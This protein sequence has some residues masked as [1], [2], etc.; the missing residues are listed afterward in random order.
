MTAPSCPQCIVTLY[1]KF[2]F[3]LDAEKTKLSKE[4]L[5]LCNPGMFL[6]YKGGVFFRVHER[7]AAAAI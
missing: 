4:G 1:Q 6:H 3:E 7:P 2:T 5:P